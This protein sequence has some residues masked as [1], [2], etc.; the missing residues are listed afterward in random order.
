MCIFCVV[1]AICGVYIRLF[2]PLFRVWL[3]FNNSKLLFSPHNNIS[4]FT[5]KERNG[6]EE[7]QHSSVL[8]T[9]SAPSSPD[10]GNGEDDDAAAVGM[11]YSIAEALIRTIHVRVFG[12]VLIIE[13]FK[14]CVVFNIF[15]GI[16]AVVFERVVVGRSTRGGGG[17][18]SNDVGGWYECC[19]ECEYLCILGA[20]GGYSAQVWDFVGCFSRD[21]ANARESFSRKLSQL[22]K[23]NFA[24]AANAGEPVNTINGRGEQQ[25][26]N[27]LCALWLAG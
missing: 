12:I 9:M 27:A 3:L 16:V 6:S 2:R 21:S 25:K 11:N 10:G 5:H 13:F 4:H 15:G 20:N 23:G 26:E 14:F 7:Q 8:T 19:C 18:D 24:T 22:G 1:A 17:N